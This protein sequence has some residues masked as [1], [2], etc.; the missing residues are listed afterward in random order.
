MI[1][2]LRRFIDTRLFQL[3]GP[4]AGPIVLVH[5]KLYI[6]PTSHGVVYFLVLLLMLAGSVNYTLSLGFV[7]TFLLAGLG[8]NGI[9]Y[10]FRN[11]A[12][13][14]I[15]ATRPRP[16]FAGERAQF[17]LRVENQSSVERFGL[18]A[19][20]PSGEVA[21]FD[22]P[23]N[24]E[25]LVAIELPAPARGR[26]PLGRVTLQTRFPLG[27]FRA[28]SYLELDVACIVYPRPESPAQPLPPPLSDHGEGAASLVGNEDFAGLRAYHA[29]DSPRRI[30]WK[31]DARGQGLLSK[32]F[33]G[34]AETQLWLDWA[35]LPAHLDRE[36]RL[37]RLTRWVLEADAAECAFGLRLP[38]QTIEP[39][40]GP[41]HRSHCLQTLALFER[42]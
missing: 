3:R 18:E 1:L 22:V 34:R 12:N 2:R 29:G 20:A 24:Q 17:V 36:A 14:R 37:S 38:N 19:L 6:L 32:V 16:V 30:A 10:T 9:L 25:T 28:W 35:S 42:D 39:A 8:L 31:A 27:L 21:T 26:L 11:M 4:Q 40:A 15:A 33:S 23:A 41:G 5:R 13:L 7:L